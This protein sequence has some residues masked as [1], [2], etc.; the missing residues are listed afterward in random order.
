VTRANS[1][2][3]F[4]AALELARHGA[5]VLLACRDAYRDGAA[6]SA[7]VRQVAQTS[8][9]GLEGKTPPRRK[10]RGRLVGHDRGR[11]DHDRREDWAS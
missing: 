7:I 5:R 1:G 2:I 3:G 11:L 6:R 9:L 4:H 8:R 10:R